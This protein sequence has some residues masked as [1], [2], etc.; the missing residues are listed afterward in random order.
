MRIVF[1]GSPP[2]A[3]PSLGALLEAGHSVELVITQPDRPAGRGRKLRPS[4][5][6]A[7]AIAR[8]LPVLEPARIRKDESV[9]GRLQSVRPDIHVVAAY[10]QFLPAS[11]TNFPPRHSVNVHFSLLP[12]YRGAS[13]VQWAI[14]N[15]ETRTGVTIFELNERMDEG[16]ILAME[17]TD[18]QSDETAHVLEMRLAV[19]GAALLIRTLND[20]D[21]IVPVPQ[22]HSLATLAPKIRKEDGA[23]DWCEE[24]AAVDRR[25]RAFQPWP[26]A[27]SFLKGKRVQIHRGLA[28]GTRFITSPPGT[29]LALGKGGLDVSCGGGSTY[30]ILSIQPEGKKEMDAHAFTI[31]AGVRAGDAF[32][33][34]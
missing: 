11:I 4:A 24:A 16:N 27:F 10:G 9:L 25:V 7:F 30:R 28:L 12:K 17:A 22:E 2:A 29:V 31:G 34:S 6:K 15:A 18:I 5:V 19:L 32:S 21:H 26:S 8:G 33:R 14:M 20:I 1:F 3:L 23:I 13:P